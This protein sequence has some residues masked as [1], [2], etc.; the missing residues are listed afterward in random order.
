[1]NPTG[2]NEEH[3][4]KALEDLWT[5]GRMSVLRSRRKALFVRVWIVFAVAWTFFIG[6]PALAPSSYGTIVTA[7]LSVGMIV[8]ALYVIV[9]FSLTLAYVRAARGWDLLAAEMIATGT[10]DV[11]AD[12]NSNTGTGGLE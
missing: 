1:M 10:G 9:C 5:S 6:W 11:R 4:D 3:V 7:G 2:R 12:T 8:C